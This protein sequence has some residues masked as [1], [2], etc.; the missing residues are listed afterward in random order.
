MTDEEKA[1]AQHREAEY[2]EFY[3]L[4]AAIN[5][6]LMIAEQP[7]KTEDDYRK[8]LEAR[9]RVWDI[10]RAIG[11]RRRGNQANPPVTQ[12]RPIN[13]GWNGPVHAG[14]PKG[15]PPINR[16]PTPPPA[17]PPKKN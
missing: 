3:E 14:G 8:S 12:P 16:E 1:D 7:K 13:E 10:C 4:G 6:A 17:P 9:R 2:K 15:P 11:E 5:R